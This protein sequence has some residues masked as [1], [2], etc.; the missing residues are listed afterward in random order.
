MMMSKPNNKEFENYL[1]SKN[2]TCIYKVLTEQ[3]KVYYHLDPC[4]LEGAPICC[5]SPADTKLIGPC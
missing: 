1:Q 2:C 3:G 5:I 4:G